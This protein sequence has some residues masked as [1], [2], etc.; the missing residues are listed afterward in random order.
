MEMMA[1]DYLSL[2]LGHPGLR[3]FCLSFMRIKLWAIGKKA[4][5]WQSPAINSDS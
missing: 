2:I 3:G 5:Q 4:A 1:A